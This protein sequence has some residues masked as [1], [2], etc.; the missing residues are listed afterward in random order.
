M[1]LLSI[2]RYYW[3][4]VAPYG[5][6]LQPM[7]E[8]WVKDGHRV[9]VFTGQPSYNDINRE[10]RAWRE[11]YNG[12]NIIRVSL[13][14]ERKKWQWL[15][16]LNFMIFLFRAALHV[17]TERKYDLIIVNSYPPILMGFCAWLINKIWKIPYIYHCQDLHPESAMIAGYLR[18]NWLY[19]ILERIDTNSCRR[20]SVVVTLSR[21]M[22]NTLD[23][24]GLGRANV[25]ILNNFI[26]D[27]YESPRKLPLPLTRK[28]EDEFHILFAGNIG[29]FQGLDSIVEAAK[30]LR[31][32]QQ[33]KFNFMGEG[34]AKA[35]LMK[36]SGKL[37]GKTINFIPH[38]PLAVAFAA[39]EQAD[40]GVISLKPNV[41][42]VAYPSKTMMYLAAGCPLLAIIEKESCIA[43][44]IVNKGIGYVCAYGDPTEI[45]KII[46]KA[47]ME[48]DILDNKRETIRQIAKGLFDRN[49]ILG[50]WSKIVDGL[51]APDDPPLMNA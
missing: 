8:G 41:Y 22:A 10:R 16:L 31:D 2:Y 12:V 25:R 15:R 33:I 37:L 40:L 23:C 48:K 9:T 38:Q 42:K 43:R 5:R 46:N 32:K 7:V 11:K 49:I 4:D 34:L 6:L 13:L 18:K 26:L 21:D 39:M 1:R 20:A 51:S 29:N 19:D 17:L 3:P 36:K 27:T 30:T 50:E 24:R 45:G 47:W 44:D 14:P 28:S 35:E